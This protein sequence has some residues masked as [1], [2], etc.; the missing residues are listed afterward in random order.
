MTSH[1][2]IP[3]T[4]LKRSIS[5]YRRLGYELAEQWERPEWGMTGQLMVI[6]S[7]PQLELI[8]HKDNVH[9]QYPSVPEVLHIAIPVL[10]LEELLKK[11]TVD[12][13]TIVRPLM[14]GITVK[15]LAFIKDPDGFS[16]ELFE[17]KV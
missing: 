14:P 11:I 16:I 1:T 15:Q 3:V 4:D 10:H 8:F 2:A 13:T 12:G 7:G 6:E 17:P 5:F 9:V